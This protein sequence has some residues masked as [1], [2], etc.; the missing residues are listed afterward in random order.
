MPD[1]TMKESRRPIKNFES[2]RTF[3]GM[4][5]FYVSLFVKVMGPPSNERS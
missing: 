2:T 4:D 3:E 5:N 1:E